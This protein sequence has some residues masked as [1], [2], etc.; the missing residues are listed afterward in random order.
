M[1]KGKREMREKHLR[2]RIEK[3]KELQKLEESNRKEIM[4][5]FQSQPIQ[6]FWA[7]HHIEF[8]TLFRYY[9]DMENVR[10]DFE[11][12]TEELSREGLH[13]MFFELGLTPAIFSGSEINLA[14]SSILRHKKMNENRIPGL[15]FSEFLQFLLR[16]VIK[17][18]DLFGKI[19]SA[20]KNNKNMP[21]SKQHLNLIL[22]QDEKED[23]ER[24]ERQKNEGNAPGKDQDVY[25]EIWKT[26]ENSLKGLLIFWNLPRQRR[27][28][29][30]KLM[31]MR[32]EQSKQI[33]KGTPILSFLPLIQ[34][35]DPSFSF[36]LT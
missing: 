22:E 14:I 24:L 15:S 34:A 33:E 16:M 26:N 29:K 4:E 7:K 3:D 30:D 5:L 12:N 9:V 6:K 27:K 23:Q 19:Y 18:K 35:L 20:T 36:L 10:I 17:E 25:D 13:R 11:S 21:I 2:K 8:E 28:I 31:R 32:K 1:E